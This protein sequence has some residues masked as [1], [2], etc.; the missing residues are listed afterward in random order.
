MKVR[1]FT[2]HRK[3]YAVDL[4]AGSCDC[5]HFAH[6]GERCKHL[7]MATVITRANQDVITEAL[8]A[9]IAERIR[10]MCAVVF[11]PVKRKESPESSARVC[12][13]ASRSVYGPEIRAAA[14][15]RH[16]KVL[17]KTAKPGRAA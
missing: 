8:R 14:W 10:A 7:V 6:T 16:R 13:E 9:E 17:A 1:S 15:K 4:E 11:A 2:D 3:S 5:P 12:Q